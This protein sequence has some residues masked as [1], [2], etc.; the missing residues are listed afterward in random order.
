MDAGTWIFIAS[1]VVAVIAWVMRFAG[2]LGDRHGHELGGASST[3]QGSNPAPD[4]GSHGTGG[5]HHA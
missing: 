2:L 1:A 3:I 4:P 5:G